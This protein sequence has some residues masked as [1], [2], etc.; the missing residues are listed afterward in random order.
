MEFKVRILDELV[1][2]ADDLGDIFIPDDVKPGEVLVRKGS[3]KQLSTNKYVPIALAYWRPAE[4]GNSEFSAFLEEDGIW[5]LTLGYAN[6]CPQIRAAFA[7]V[8]I[9]V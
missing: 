2:L 4:E 1:E 3:I 7:A 8:G 6:P 5:S 9:F